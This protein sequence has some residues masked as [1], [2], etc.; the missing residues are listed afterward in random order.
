MESPAFIDDEVV[1]DSEEDIEQGIYSC[2]GQYHPRLDTF[3]LSGTTPSTG[4]GSSN[5]YVSEFPSH[6]QPIKAISSISAF[7]A[8]PSAL[9]DHPA[10]FISP[11]GKGKVKAADTS[12]TDFVSMPGTIAD[13]AKARQRTQKPSLVTSDVDDKEFSLKPSKPQ[14]K[15][16]PKPK[17]KPKTKPE[18]V[19]NTPNATS[20]SDPPP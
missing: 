10:R 8:G 1:V 11:S 13:R 2:R 3:R 17:A 4:L 16:Q 9:P 15:S 12:I 20:A 14:S 18:Q 6:I 5:P 19:Q 7:T